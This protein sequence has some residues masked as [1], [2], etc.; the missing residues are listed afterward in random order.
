MES[1]ISASI[2]GPDRTLFQVFFWTL[3]RD[4]LIFL[5]W[6]RLAAGLV[7]LLSSEMA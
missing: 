7:R 1:E 5:I 6:M 3:P 2:M 4:F